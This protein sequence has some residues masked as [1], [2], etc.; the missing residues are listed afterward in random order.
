MEVIVLLITEQEVKFKLF[1]E[2]QGP[3]YALSKSRIHKIRFSNGR[4]EVYNDLEAYVQGLEVNSPLSLP[5]NNNPS[6]NSL[7]AEQWAAMEGQAYRDATENYD[8]RGAFWGNAAA[9]FLFPPAGL[10][11]AI[12]TSL[13]P[14]LISSGSTSQKVNF[15]AILFI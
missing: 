9:S 7:T 6:G 10:I 1:A 5:A 2:P 11:S 8:P 14:R 4:E 12:A 3:E 15:Q 13:A